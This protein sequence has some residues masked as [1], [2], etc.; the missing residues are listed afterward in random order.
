MTL[1]LNGQ[2]LI[3]NFNSSRNIEKAISNLKGILIGIT[4]DK[5][6]NEQE[7]LFLDVWLK[8]EDN[9]KDDPDCIDLLDLIGDILEDGIITNDELDELHNLINDVIHYKSYDKNENEA[10]INELIGLISGIVADSVITNS[11]I[12]KLTGW[13][14][15]NHHIKNE[16]P[17]NIIIQRLTDILDDGIIT[18]DERIGL[19]ETIKQITGV[20]FDESGSAHGTS[21]EFFEDSIEAIVHID[22]CFCFTGKFVSGPRKSIEDS[23]KDKGATT[24]KDVSQNVDYLVVGTLA[25]RD[26]RF[27]SHGRKIEKAFKLKEKGSTINIITEETWLKYA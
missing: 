26:W 4:A 25:S 16:W 7:L 22:S 20:R 17:A 15:H 5:Q 21:T 18:E 1:D 11:E 23:A 13:L 6:L 3:S 9:L 12:E 24:K 27:S 19:I 8:S 2:P 14:T 10:Q